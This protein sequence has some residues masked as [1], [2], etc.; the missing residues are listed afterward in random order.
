MASFLLGTGEASPCSS[1]PGC[2]RLWEGQKQILPGDSVG[3]HVPRPHGRAETQHGQP[4]CCTMRPGCREFMPGSCIPGTLQPVLLAPQTLHHCQHR[5]ALLAPQTPHHWHR[6][7][8]AAGVVRPA[9]PASES[10]HQCHCRPQMAATAHPAHWHCGLAL[11]ALGSCTAGTGTLHCWH[12]DPALLAL[13]HCT[14]GTGI[15]HCW[16]WGPCIAGTGILHCWHW[17]TALLVL[18]HCAA[19]TRTLHCWCWDPALLALG[20][21]TAGTGDPALLALG[22]GPAGLHGWHPSAEGTPQPPTCSGDMA[23]TG[24][25]RA[26][27]VSHCSI[28]GGQKKAAALWVCEDAL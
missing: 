1:A 25:R 7:P 4:R 2:S 23:V 10:P 14:A 8:C 17:D 15:L 9:L 20:S 11:L 18:G 21:C 16:H 13:G 28:K 6:G 27:A 12:L 5:P 19:G 24:I 22:P 26:P 3:T